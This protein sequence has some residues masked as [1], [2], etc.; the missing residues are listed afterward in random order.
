MNL[1]YPIFVLEVHKKFIYKIDTVKEIG[2]GSHALQYELE[3]V[4]GHD[5]INPDENDIQGFV[6]NRAF[7]E[8]VQY[9]DL[10]VFP[11]EESLGERLKEEGY[12]VINIDDYKIHPFLGGED[13]DEI[14]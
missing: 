8:S 13:D 3:L 14:F 7:V 6:D 2:S 11:L 1:R 4:A 12:R 9:E 5:Y 10:T